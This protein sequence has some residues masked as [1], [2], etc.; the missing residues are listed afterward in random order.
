MKFKTHNTIGCTDDVSHLSKKEQKAQLKERIQFIEK[1]IQS[2]KKDMKA[3]SR[4]TRK[5]CYNDTYVT[6]LIW[7]CHIEL[8]DHKSELKSLTK[9]SEKQ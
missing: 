9:Q 4:L 1:Q 6:A 3:L 5:Y 7:T 2:F 8:A